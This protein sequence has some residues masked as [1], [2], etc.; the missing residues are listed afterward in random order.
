MK[1]Y[2]KLFET[3]SDIYPVMFHCFSRFDEASEY[4]DTGHSQLENSASGS[5]KWWNV[6][7]KYRL[8]K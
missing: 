1:G 2:R 8:I 4:K 5:I 7:I 3:F 6:E